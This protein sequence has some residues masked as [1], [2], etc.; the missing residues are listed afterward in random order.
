MGLR[1]VF[2]KQGGKDLLR[3][4]LKGG[5]LFTAISEFLLLG[6][7]RTAL[8]L[9][10]LSAQYKIKKKLDRKYKWV[11]NDFQNSCVEKNTHQVSNKVWT[12]W[13]QGI[14]NAPN[15]VKQC[16]ESLKKNLPDKEIVLI[17]KD[18]L[19]EYVTFP[20]YIIDKWNKG[21]ITNTHMT[22]LLRLE[23]LI[24]Y[25]GMWVD[26]TV[27]CTSRSEE[28]P[29][30]FFDSDLF[31]FQ[32]LKPGRDGCS[33]Y[34]SSWLISAKTNNKVLMLTRELCYQYWKVNNN[35]VDYFLLHDFISIA[36]DVFKEDWDNIVPR[37]NATPHILLLRLFDDYNEELYKEIL[38]QTPFSKLS[39]K[40]SEKQL[41]KN[42][43]F[44][45]KILLK[46]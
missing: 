11:I 25:G 38:Q 36:L 13:F 42:N 44:Y 35:M 12:C 1:S 4:Y 46:K 6:K 17:T 5:A 21:I 8:E 30:Y 34:V 3:Q 41:N 23:L 40:F 45:E 18:N 19:S 28:I 16:F 20:D 22:D 33:H 39:Y 26:A 2:Q 15:I 43:T 29:S 31:M 7:E 24:K 27:L 32:N 14:E 10:R 37:D 9:L